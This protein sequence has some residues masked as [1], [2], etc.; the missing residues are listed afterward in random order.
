MATEFLMTGF[1]SMFYLFPPGHFTNTDT[2]KVPDYT[3]RAIPYFFLF[4]LIE[5]VIG[6]VKGVKLYRLNDTMMSISLGVFMLVSRVEGNKKNR[7][8]IL[9]HLP[10][11]DCILSIER[12]VV[13]QRT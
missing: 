10:I 5:L 12:F 4:M 8:A 9:N 13:L 3:T 7:W 6:W 1:R 11:F 2:H